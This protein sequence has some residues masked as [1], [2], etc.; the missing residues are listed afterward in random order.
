MNTRSIAQ[1][2]TFVLAF[3]IG[4]AAYSG[5]CQRLRG[6]EQNSEDGPNER[7]KAIISRCL[8]RD[9]SIVNGYAS[10][11]RPVHGVTRLSWVSPMPEDYRD[12]ALIGPEAVKP[13]SLL[14]EDR[15]GFANLLSV[16]FL[17]RI[18]GPSVFRALVRATNRDEWDVV[19]FTAM[20]EIAASPN[21][22]TAAIIKRMQND[23]DPFIAKKAREI[24]ARLSQRRPK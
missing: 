11:G 6:P 7:V 2:A 14:L 17:I 12:M 20:E 23:K 15:G 4:P 9:Y 24:V 10:D 5:F 13:L 21:A 8:A 3:L 19:R 22:E 18:G 1:A 16:K